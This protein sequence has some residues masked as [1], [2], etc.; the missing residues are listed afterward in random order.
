MVTFCWL[1]ESFLIMTIN[2]CRPVV[3]DLLQDDE[4]RITRVLCDMKE[5]RLLRGMKNTN[6]TFG[7]EICIAAGRNQHWPSDT[8]GK[9]LRTE[10]ES[11]RYAR[12][13]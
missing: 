11:L 1:V 2:P 5:R 12:F 13:F 9:P 6:S 7:C 4:L 8:Q 3:Q 10:E